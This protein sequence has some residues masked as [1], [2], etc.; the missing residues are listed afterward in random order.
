MRLV[1]L[2]ALIIGITIPAMGEDDFLKA[3]NSGDVATVQSMLARDSA[4][5]NAK[6]AKGTSAVISAL[7]INKGE[8]FLDPAKNEILHAILA[9]KPHLDIFETA[10]LGTASQLDAMLTDADSVHRRN[11]FG[12]TLLH[13][14]AFGG[15]VATTEL[16][17]KKGA[18]IE[19]RAGSKFRN[20][21]LQ[22]A[23]LSNQYATAKILLD[24]GA[25][26]LV[27][28]SKGFT[29]MHEGA[30]SGRIDIIQ[31]LL[32]HGAE[33]NSVADNGQT[34]LAEA[35]RGKHDDVVAWM[36]TKGAVVGIQV[37]DE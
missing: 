10:A 32:D 2:A 37:I 11:H 25:D 21:P 35:M 13:I 17:L 24:H 14:A 1:L 18:T 9:Q 4:L 3:V 16:L 20:T 12:W 28:Q 31:L 33:I 23:L 7:F 5:A 30:I 29:P 8:G 26:A 15:N 19:S 22:T 34:P 6:N 27:R 36:K